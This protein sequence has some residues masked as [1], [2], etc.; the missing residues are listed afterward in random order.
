VEW[1]V[2]YTD[3]FEAWWEG[4]TAEERDSADRLYEEHLRP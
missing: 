4:L 2:E 1:E 3:Q